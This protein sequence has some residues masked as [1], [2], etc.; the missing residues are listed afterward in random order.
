MKQCLKLFTRSHNCSTD[1]LCTNKNGSFSC[2]C[3]TGMV[4]DGYFCITDIGE[5]NATK[6]Y[7]T[8]DPASKNFNW[9]YQNLTAED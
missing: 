1:A 9:T 2:A 4:G 3:F 6:N 7:K 8:N 5:Q